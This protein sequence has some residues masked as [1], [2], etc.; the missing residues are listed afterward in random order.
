[1][2][3]SVGDQIIREGLSALQAQGLSLAAQRLQVLNAAS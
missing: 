3:W 2:Q 1:V